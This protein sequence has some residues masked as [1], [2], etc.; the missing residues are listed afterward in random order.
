MIR[1]QTKQ[2]LKKNFHRILAVNA[3]KNGFTETSTVSVCL[4]EYETECDTGEKHI[5]AASACMSDEIRERVVPEDN[6]TKF[7]SLCREYMLPYTEEEIAT[8]RDFQ[9][10]HDQLMLQWAKLNDSA[11]FAALATDLPGLAVGFQERLETFQVMCRKLG[12][13]VTKFGDFDEIDS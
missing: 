1:E 9:Q 10:A 6:C 11:K 7:S 2:L 4:Y 8:I 3:L 13:E 5:C 12:F